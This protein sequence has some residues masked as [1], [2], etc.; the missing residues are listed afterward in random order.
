MFQDQHQQVQHL[1]K[2][3]PF[4]DLQIQKLALQFDVK[5]TSNFRN[6]QQ[7]DQKLRVCHP[8]AVEER[9]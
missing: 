4:V 7:F 2:S 5:C 9:Q 3:L 8:N 6:H 1:I